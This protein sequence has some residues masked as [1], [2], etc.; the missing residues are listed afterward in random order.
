MIKKGVIYLNDKGRIYLGRF[1]K[2]AHKVIF[3][4]DGRPRKEYI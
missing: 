3:P 4:R 1:M 2:G